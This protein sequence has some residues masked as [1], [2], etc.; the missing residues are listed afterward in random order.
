VRLFVAVRPPTGALDHAAAA[1]AAVRAA[2]VGPRWIPP[3][4]WHLTLAFYGE[5]PDGEV[6]AVRDRLDGRV[7]G[8]A[9]LSLA[10]VGAGAF[11]RRAVWLGVSGDLG[12]L[13]GL[14]RLVSLD[15]SRPYRPHLT[16][17]RLRGDTDPTATVAALSAY[18]GP[19]WS[20]AAVHLVRSQPGP[21]PAYDDIASW[22]LTPQP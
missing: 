22:P 4:R 14:A 13:R 2:H 20:A 10:V 8:A 16:V 9:D 1:V 17:A 12:P 3:E 11:S 6:D 15:H 21:V 7:R 19:A 18:A 5:V